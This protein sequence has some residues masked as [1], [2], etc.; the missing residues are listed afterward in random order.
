MAVSPLRKTKPVQKN[1][2]RRCLERPTSPRSS[3]MSPPPLKTPNYSIEKDKYN[4]KY[5][6]PSA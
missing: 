4:K 6:L 3:S 5:L 2:K 1:P